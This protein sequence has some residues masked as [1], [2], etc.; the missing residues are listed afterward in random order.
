MQSKTNSS[1]NVNSVE[2]KGKNTRS[3]KPK[4]SFY[5]IDGEQTSVHLCLLCALC[6]SERYC[7]YCCYFGSTVQTRN[8]PVIQLTNEYLDEMFFS[9]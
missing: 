7:V 8:K 2:I 3:W 6:V 1:A 4:Y 5:V 9:F